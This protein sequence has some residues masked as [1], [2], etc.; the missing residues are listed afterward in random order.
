MK[1]MFI[2]EME[3]SRGKQ[4]AKPSDM[5]M[6]ITDDKIEHLAIYTLLSP[7]PGQDPSHLRAIAIVETESEEALHSSVYSLLLAGAS[8]V[9]VIPVKERPIS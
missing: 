6:N 1:F 3:P 2:I 9:N 4:V 5:M 7:M 8:N